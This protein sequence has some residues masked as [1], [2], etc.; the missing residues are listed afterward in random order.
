MDGDI[1]IPA[2]SSQTSTSSN[3]SIEPPSKGEVKRQAQKEALQEI[4]WDHDALSPYPKE[5][6]ET[7]SAKALNGEP[8]KDA[9]EQSQPQSHSSLLASTRPPAS[10]H[11]HEQ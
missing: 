1:P 2:G 5:S 4:R 11:S 8:E 3:P 6:I 10:G 7:V 9:D